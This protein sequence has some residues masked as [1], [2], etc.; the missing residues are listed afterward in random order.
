MFT[1]QT[2]F[3]PLFAW[4]KGGGALIEVTVNSMEK[5]LLS[6]LRPRIRPQESPENILEYTY[7]E[8]LYWC[9]MRRDEKL[10]TWNFFF[11]ER[12]QYQ[13][14]LCSIVQFYIFMCTRI[15]MYVGCLIGTRARV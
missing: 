11:V 14:K 10:S 6:P 9:A 3:K 2:S 8:R 12:L 4:R 1:L 5:R 13:Q 7:T 15:Y